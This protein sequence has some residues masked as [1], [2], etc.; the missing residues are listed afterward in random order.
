MEILGEIL[1]IL[2]I[3]VAVYGYINI[4]REG[5]EIGANSKG[6]GIFR[7]VFS[8]FGQCLGAGIDAIYYKIKNKN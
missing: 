3:G 8:S 1:G 5:R 4:K 2:M 7:Y 6:K